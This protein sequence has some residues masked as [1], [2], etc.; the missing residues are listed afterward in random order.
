MTLSWHVS[1][2]SLQTCYEMHNIVKVNIIAINPATTGIFSAIQLFSILRKKCPSI[3]VLCCILFFANFQKFRFFPKKKSIF[4]T[5]KQ[6]TLLSYVFKNPFYFICILYKFAMVL[7]WKTFQDKLVQS[8]VIVQSCN[9][10]VNVHKM[11]LLSGWFSF[12]IPIGAENK[13][14]HVQA[15]TYHDGQVWTSM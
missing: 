11:H 4:S 12:H 2:Q 13:M 15:M 1:R 7:W 8:C 5:K 14:Q 6:K 3:C 9:W 10:Q